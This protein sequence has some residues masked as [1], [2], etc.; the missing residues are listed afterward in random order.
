MAGLYSHTTRAT[1]LVLTANIYNTDHQNHIDN[2]IPAQIDDYSSSVAEMQSITDP[3]PASSEDQ[4]ASLAGELE[5]LRY[6]L[7]QITGAAQWYVDPATDIAT[8][9][10][11]LGTLDATAK[12][13]ANG[14]NVIANRLFL[15]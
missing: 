14:Q 15:F 10:T 12:G 5:R 1:G 3:Y 6:V 11:T 9:N 2:S 13:P 8:I 4:A 7:K